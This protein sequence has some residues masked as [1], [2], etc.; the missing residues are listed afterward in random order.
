MTISGDWYEN[1]RSAN[2]AWRPNAQEAAQADQ[3]RAQKPYHDA[4]LTAQGYTIVETYEYT[5]PS[6]HP[7]YFSRRYERRSVGSKAFRQGHYDAAAENEYAGAGLDK[8]PYRWPHLAA[9]DRAETVFWCEGE[10]DADT[11]TRLGLVATTAAGQVLSATIAKALTGRNVV[12]LVDNDDK[13]E[14][15]AANAVA[16]FRHYAASLRVLRLPNLDR[17]ED[18]TDW[19]AKGG[20]VEDLTR[21]AAEE[22]CVIA[23]EQRGAIRASRFA[24]CGDDEIPWPDYVYGTGYIRGILSI[25][26]SAG[27]LGKSAL[28]LT[29]A[30]AMTTG[31]PLLGPAPQ[32]PL[33]VWYINLEDGDNVL[34]PRLKAAAKFHGITNADIGDRLFVDTSDMKLVL[35]EQDEWGRATLNPAVITRLVREIKANRIDVVMIDPLVS[36]NKINENGTDMDL[37]A[38]ELARVARQTN[39][40]IMVVHHV[41]K[42]GQEERTASHV[43]GSGS[44]VNA[45]R[46]VRVINPMT[47][48]DANKAGVDPERRGYYFRIDDG[49]TNLAPAE[50]STWFERVNYDEFSFDDWRKNVVVLKP[51]TFAASSAGRLDSLTQMDVA[52]AFADGGPWRER[53]TSDRWA[54]YR[55]A[56]H[57]GLG[58]QSRTERAALQQAISEAVRRGW[59]VRFDAQDATRQPRPHVKL[60]DFA[61]AGASG[62]PVASDAPC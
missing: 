10:K 60:A 41:T 20:T 4:D 13:G 3:P 59:L 31:K 55:L 54:G 7:I 27:G 57:L 15:N 28:V 53:G 30:L 33:R 34:V 6:G 14:E 50:S 29:E 37:V 61:P 42:G 36:A 26:A 38:K 62:A 44:L 46:V 35:A 49:K 19:F 11:L 58:D 47:A 32:S 24:L 45:A 9:A 23:E 16:A 2:G 43:R 12:V 22:P 52:A 1:R 25:T 40:A 48:D 17:S 39:S 8:V 18:V 21:L 5:D 51:F 56:A